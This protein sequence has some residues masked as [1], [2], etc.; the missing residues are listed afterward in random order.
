MLNPIFE[1]TSPSDFWGRKWNLVVHGILKRGVYK[2]VRTRCSRFV[3]SVATFIASG[4]FH[5]WLL[6]LVFHPESDDGEC[7]PIC[8]TPGFG[9]NTLFFL[10]CA[11]FIGL[12]YAIGSAAV[13]QVLRNNLPLTVVS[14]MVVSLA[15]PVAHWFTND[16]VR[17]DFFIDCQTGF[18]IIVRV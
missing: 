17:S 4:L 16:Y 15:L 8:Y 1:S 2:P 10:W 12:E 5:E 14:L 7:S 9:R 11:F 18:P 3:A 6:T 13:F